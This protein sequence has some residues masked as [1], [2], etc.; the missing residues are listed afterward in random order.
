MQKLQGRVMTTGLAFPEGPVALPDGSVPVVEIGAARL[1]R[2]LPSGE[3]DVIAHVGG[4]PNGAAVGPDRRAA[5]ITLSGYGQLF[6]AHWPR[7]GLDL[8]AWRA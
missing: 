3:R 8:A 4:G 2:I 7:A 6:E 1:T 5:Y